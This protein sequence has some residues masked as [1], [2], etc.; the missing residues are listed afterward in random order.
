MYSL[1]RKL[2]FLLDAEDAHE[3][4]TAQMMRLQQIPLVLHAIEHFCAPPASARR[5]VMGLSFSSPIGIAAGFDKNGLLMPML[6]ALGFGFVEVGT[7]TLRPQPGNPRPRLFRFPEQKALINRLGFNND[8]A[9]A[10][11]ARLKSWTRTVPLFVNIGKNRD[12]P[13]DAAADDYGACAAKLAPFAD[14]VVVNLSS[15][16]TPSLRELQRPEHLER[17]LTAVG[18]ALVKIA[19][20]IDDTMLAEICDVCVNRA[21]GMICTNTTV[22]RPFP[23][24]EAGGLSGAPLMEPST[25]ILGRVRQRVGPSFPL[26]GVGGILTADDVRA[27]LTAGADLVQVYT[28]FIYQGP[29]MARRLVRTT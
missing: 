9:D 2:L 26:V 3:L 23:A 7:V 21:R 13:I 25:S 19:P 15:P 27:K 1:I 20:D 5:E 28:G 14:A 10:V 17:I 4:T 11:A 16:N 6:A 12:V 24:S 18:P 8:G 29:L 22:A